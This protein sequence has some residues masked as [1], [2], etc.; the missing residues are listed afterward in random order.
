VRA[1]VLTGDRGDDGAPIKFING[2]TVSGASSGLRASA[3]GGGALE[4][5]R[6]RRGG[7]ARKESKGRRGEA[8]QATGGERLGTWRGGKLGAWAPGCGEL[9]NDPGPASTGYG[10]RAAP[11]TSGCGAA[12]RKKREGERRLAGGPARGMG[13][14]SISETRRVG[15]RLAGGPG[16]HSAGQ[17]GLKWIQRYSLIQTNLKISKL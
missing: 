14:P 8:S 1:A 11:R 10:R 16:Q 7:R 15:E 9:Q 3:E 17:S 12:T 4:R 5:A 2:G 13:A 6:V